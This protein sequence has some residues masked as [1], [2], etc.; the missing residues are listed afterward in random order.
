MGA[1]MLT[2]IASLLATEYV[3]QVLEQSLDGGFPASTAAS[4]AG[5]PRPAAAPSVK[6]QPASKL[7]AAPPAGASRPAVSAVQQKPP[8][9]EPPPAEPPPSPGAF[10]LWPLA[11]AALAVVAGAAAA[12]KGG[13]QSSLA[14]RHVARPLTAQ[15]AVT[16]SER[17]ALRRAR[18]DQ[19]YSRLPARTPG[20]V[21]PLQPIGTAEAEPAAATVAGDS[22]ARRDEPQSGS[23]SVARGPA[24]TVSERQALLRARSDQWYSRLPARTP[25]A[26]EP[27]QPIGTAEA[28]SGSVF[29]ARGRTPLLWSGEGDLRPSSSGGPL[30][31]LDYSAYV[32]P[33]LVRKNAGGTG[34]LASLATLPARGIERVQ[35]AN[36]AR[37]LAARPVGARVPILA[38]PD[39]VPPPPPVRPV[40]V[41]IPERAASDAAQKA[42]SVAILRG[43]ADA[44]SAQRGTLAALFA[45]VDEDKSVSLDKDELR[46]MITQKLGVELGDGEM[47]VIWSQLDADGSVR[48]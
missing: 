12:R 18:S 40:E 6:L 46:E 1:V 5:P 21:E 7:P 44:L 43:L 15:T 42:A 23:A 20:A 27:L 45:E 32:L 37:A 41:A 24:V 9:V 17:Q 48:V 14:R 30:S 13:G 2:T 3:M 47:E 4:P 22:L 38:E 11:C 8:P 25:G 35:P 33:A 28:Q 16:V 31:R 39:P 36:A 29:V 19:W 26:V 34:L 10:S